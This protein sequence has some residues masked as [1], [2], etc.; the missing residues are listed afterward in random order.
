MNHKFEIAGHKGYPPSA[1]SRTA[2]PGELFIQMNKE[3]STI[4]GLM[5]TMRP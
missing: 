2:Q 5:D 4:G 3:G 1:C